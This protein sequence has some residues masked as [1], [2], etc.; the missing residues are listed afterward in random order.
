MEPVD[1]VARFIRVLLG[2]AITVRVLQV[3]AGLIKHA[4]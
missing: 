1:R 2:A 3:A 4:F